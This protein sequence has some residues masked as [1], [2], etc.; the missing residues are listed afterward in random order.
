MAYECSLIAE[1]SDDTNG[2]LR[3]VVERVVFVEFDDGSYERSA[4]SGL[5]AVGFETFVSLW[6]RTGYEGC[7]ALSYEGLHGAV[8]VIGRIWQS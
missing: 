3:I 7:A 4:E 6:L 8:T 1:G 5:V 2:V